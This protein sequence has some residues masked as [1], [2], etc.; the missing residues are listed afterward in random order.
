MRCLLPWLQITI[1]PVLVP[2]DAAKDYD[3]LMMLQDARSHID[4][5]PPWLPDAALA[6]GLVMLACLQIW[7]FDRFP[8]P[9]GAL[10]PVGR[11]PGR[12]GVMPYLLT[13][14]VFGPLALRRVWPWA[15]LLA[16]GAFAI[17]YGLHPS[18]ASFTT[19]GPMVGMYS[20]AAYARR[21]YSGLV[22]LVVTGLVLAVPVIA[23]TS[24]RG[25]A[26]AVGT[27]ALLA[28]AMLFG[29]TTRNHREYTVEVERRAAQ[30]ER[31]A[32]EEA[33]R[34]ADEERM[35]I[36]REV[37]DIVA[38]SLSIIAVQAGAAVTLMESDTGEA[39]QSIQHIRDVSKE[40]LSELR[41]ML[42][43][44]R[45]GEG[46]L[47]LAPTAEL[48][49]LDALIAPLRRAGLDVDLVIKGDLSRIPAF[50]SVSAYRV[51]Q[52]ALTNV[53]RHSHARRVLVAIGLENDRLSLEI[54]DEGPHST[55]ED[56]PSGH[57][58]RGMRERVE[59]LGGSFSA[60][61]NAAGQG[62]SVQ[63]TIPLTRGAS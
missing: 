15:S 60:A 26:Q 37:H 22:A 38:H 28:A 58:L 6:L 44:L 19:L 27:F 51:V 3:G 31:A 2:T 30:A 12:P 29:D 61:T 20:V 7:L 46:G 16:S 33:R 63:A 18:P 24:T 59:T 25:A 41:S 62:F 36:A 45:T 21:R 32:K 34:R 50:A 5:L 17:L 39:R 49:Q 4:D 10:G 13:C 55:L 53:V 56:I 35:R 23:F 42:D 48:T 1:L 52:E 47:P 9:M 11:P 43:V 54:S 8:P 57:G 40:A 14:G